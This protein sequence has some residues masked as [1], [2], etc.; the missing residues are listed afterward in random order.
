LIHNLRAG[1]LKA[2]PSIDGDQA[3]VLAQQLPAEHPARRAM[4][5]LE[6]PPEWEMYDLRQ[7]PVEF[8]NRADDPG[9]A[10][11]VNRLQQALSDWQQ[12]TEDPFAGVE[13]RRMVEAKYR[14]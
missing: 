11:E 9:L 5:R 14:K 7:D 12:R 8:V 10:A 1:E 2:S 13:F 4:E 6:N 3:H